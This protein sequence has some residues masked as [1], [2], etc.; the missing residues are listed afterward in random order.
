MKTRY[1]VSQIGAKFKLHVLNNFRG[2]NK[3]AAE[4]YGVAATVISN[5]Y[6]GRKP[7]T[8]TMLVDMGFKKIT[9]ETYWVKESK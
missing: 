6:A 3:D 8:K 5:I 9:P 7:P 4:H 1:N 2:R